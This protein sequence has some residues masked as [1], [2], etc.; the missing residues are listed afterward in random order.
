MVSVKIEKIGKYTYI[1]CN[2]CNQVLLTNDQEY[3]LTKIKRN[4]LYAVSSC[5]HFENIS[6]HKDPESLQNLKEIRKLA[7]LEYEG[8]Y[9]ITFLVPRQS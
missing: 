3:L 6:I 5:E 7:L 4:E 1:K 9:Y 2:K 8:K